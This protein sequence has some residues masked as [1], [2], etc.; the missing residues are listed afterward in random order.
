MLPL[1]KWQLSRNYEATEGQ[2]VGWGRGKAGYK[3][4][5]REGDMGRDSKTKRLHE[6]TDSVRVPA[7]W[8]PSPPE[9]RAQPASQGKIHRADHRKELNEEQ[10]EGVAGPCLVCGEVP[11]RVGGLEAGEVPPW[12]GASQAQKIHLCIDGLIL[13][14]GVGL[15]E[16]SLTGQRLG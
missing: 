5:K 10:K 12:V 6:Q 8:S 13:P 2:R 9:D 3:E 15:W 14:C 11:F 4:G 7:P 1:R 16:H